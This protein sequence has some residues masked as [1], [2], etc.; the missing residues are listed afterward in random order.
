MGITSEKK[1]VPANNN[2]MN[3]PANN[4]S[5]N[6]NLNFNHTLGS[7]VKVEFELDEFRFNLLNANLNNNLKE[8]KCII[9]IGDTDFIFLK[10]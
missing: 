8:K 10:T 2:S 4:Q 7:K 1:T 3:I 9:S 5:I 6:K